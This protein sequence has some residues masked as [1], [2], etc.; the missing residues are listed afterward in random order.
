MSGNN[1]LTGCLNLLATLLAIFTFVTGLANLPQI[2]SLL[3][4]KADFRTTPFTPSFAP[5][6]TVREPTDTEAIRQVLEKWEAIHI[7]TDRTLDAGSLDEVL[8]KDALIQQQSDLEEM[9]TS[10]CYWIIESVEPMQVQTISLASS[11][12]AK[13]VVYKNYEMDQYCN[14]K[15]YE[16]AAF[17][18]NFLATYTMHRING[19]WY[20]VDQE[21]KDIPD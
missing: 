18:G 21:I 11:D 9:R 10:N 13:A 5:D 6:T 15:K 8:A 4:N 20:I 1:R 12:S 14:G 2:M 3:S 16:Q 17:D 7:E 19:R